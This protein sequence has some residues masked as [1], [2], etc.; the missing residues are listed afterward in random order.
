[1][2]VA[3]S[4]GYVAQTVYYRHHEYEQ[5]ESDLF[6]APHKQVSFAAQSEELGELHLF[7]PVSAF[8]TT[9]SRPFGHRCTFQL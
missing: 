7:Y 4:I 2:F 5:P 6:A 8:Y 1:M 9:F 3:K